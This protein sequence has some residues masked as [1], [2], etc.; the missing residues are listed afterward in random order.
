MDKSLPAILLNYE[1][2]FSLSTL[3]TV[4]TVQS[5]IQTTKILR[6]FDANGEYPHPYQQLKPYDH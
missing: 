1:S 3:E 2:Q 6:I 4:Q 5:E